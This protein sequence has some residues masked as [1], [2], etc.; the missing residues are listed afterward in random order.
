MKI[1]IIFFMHDVSLLKDIALAIITAAFAA[2]ILRL[3]KQPLILAYIIGGI[4]LGPNLGLSLVHD[5]I[6][7]E[8]ISE[9]GLI[10]LL[11]IIGLEINLSHLLG[12]G[13]SVFILSLTQF[14]AGALI[15]AA[16]F[17]LI[18]IGAFEGKYG[19]IYAAVALNLS[20]TLIA[21]KILK[22]KF[23]T[24]TAAGKITIGILVIQDIWA[25]IFMALQPNFSNPNISQLSRS[26]FYG[27]L[28]LSFCFI[29]SKYLL[30]SFFKKSS[31]NPELIVLSAAAWC[32]LCSSLAE[33]FG[34]SKEMGALIAGISIAS[35]PYGEDVISKISGIRDFFVTL[36]FVSLGLK[37]PKPSAELF[38]FSAYALI[39]VIATRFLTV[40][41]PGKFLKI[42]I[43]PSFLAALNLSQISEFSLVISAVGL[44]YGHIS[45]KAQSELLAAT[46]FCA[47]ISTYLISYND[48]I[49]SFFSGI[50]P[51]DS[52]E[53]NQNK[54]EKIRDILLLGYFAEAKEFI[55]LCAAK[56]KELCERIFVADFNQQNAKEINSFGAKW[57]YADLANPDSLSHINEIKPVLIICPISDIFLK[58]TDNLKL[59]RSVK[60]IFPYAKTVFTADNESKEK[61][62]MAAGAD[63]CLFPRKKTAQE[64]L[65]KTE[66]FILE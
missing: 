1:S 18:K 45:A 55:R 33:K 48:K 11:F 61:E 27:L 6:N 49:F 26:L 8:L 29:F 42:G 39:I 30:S 31:K 59:L 17:S 4:V 3:I 53:K 14:F 7:I 2:H 36:F 15:T 58:G 32:F 10:F 46:M 40:A 21:V 38:I 50:L 65:L 62:L 22:D 9:I 51:K 44:S 37:F 57:H 52:F 34:L 23:E 12:I 28:L 16:A 5:Q 63:Y 19:L 24:E 54:P 43:R 13:K 35:F 56:N 47:L 64:I 20:S 41:L 25:I 60:R 66:E